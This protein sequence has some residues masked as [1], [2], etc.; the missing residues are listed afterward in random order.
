MT[1]QEPTTKKVDKNRAII[2]FILGIVGVAGF[3]AGMV[4]IFDVFSGEAMAKRRAEIKQNRS[5]IVEIRNELDSVKA[6]QKATRK[7]LWRALGEHKE[8]GKAHTN[9][10]LVK[11]MMEKHD[12]DIDKLKERQL[13]HLITHKDK[14]C[15]S[16]GKA[17]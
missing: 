2:Y 7:D 15:A 10:D 17:Q 16:N 6:D 9:S 11:Y 4:T 8:D 3:I 12:R 14:G 1:D 13:N 5:N